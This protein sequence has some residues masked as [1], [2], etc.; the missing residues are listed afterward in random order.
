MAKNDLSPVAD[1]GGAGGERWV[2]YQS[3]LDA[4]M[5]AFGRAAIEA[6]APTAGERVLDIGCGAGATSL[7]LASRVGA[8]GHVLGIDI[9]GPL[10]D[11]ACT[12]ASQDASV[13]FQLADAGRA[14]LPGHAFDLLFSRFGVMFFD[15]PAA[16]FGHMR[17]ALKPDG[18]V[19][20]VCWRR[21]AENDWMRLPLGA[22]TGIVPPMTPP[23]Q[24]ALGAF[25]FGDPDRV[26]GIL[27]AA[28][29]ID[30]AVTPFDAPVPFGE[31]ETRDAAIEDAVAMTLDVGPLSIVLADQPDDICERAS[32]A[33]REAIADR[34]GERAVMMG[35]AAWIV[36]A[37]N[38]AD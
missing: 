32:A 26:T 11:Q 6:A 3:R 28:G 17:R 38:Q 1:W 37:R 4:M 22:L 20:F 27:S 13:R 7:D 25:S 10:I 35:G 29:F 34:A 23:D 16:A 15:D 30:V 21:L 19:A 12:L 33:V 36:T 14:N 5:A 8:Q 9:S 18:R 24:E 31:G 2:A